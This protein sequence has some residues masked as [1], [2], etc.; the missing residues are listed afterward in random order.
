M[1]TD[2]KKVRYEVLATDGCARRGRLHTRCGTVETP[3]FMPVGTHATVKGMRPDELRELG[4]DILLSNAF[5]L[6]LRPGDE[7]IARH[8]GLHRFMGWDGC[9][10]TDSGGYQVFSLAKLRRISDDGVSFSSPIDGASVFLSPER[11]MDIQH[12]IGADIIMVLDQCPGYPAPRQE[13]EEAVLRS[14]SWA[15]RCRAH[16]GDRPSSLFAIIQGGMHKDLRDRCLTE[17]AAMD[18]DGYA[19]G[20]LAVGEEPANRITML[21][22]LA[23]R[24]PADKPR[25][26]MGVGTPLDLVESVRAGVDMFDCVLPTRNA[27]NGHLYVSQG[28]LR[29]RNAAHRNSMEPLD[30]E[31]DC[32]TCRRYSRAYLHHLYSRN[33]M[34]AAHL[35]TQHNLH[36]YRTLMEK[37]RQA[38]T[39]G[40]LDEYADAFRQRMA[41]NP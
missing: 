24:M 35:G 11:C 39:D 27:R 41:S 19:I 17:L 15:E 9:L 36:Y 18:F 33:E 31:C 8:G 29:I 28:V 5:H 6:S 1:S 20:G 40:K 4:F 32:L 2:K 14:L 13:V 25:Y 23:P 22:W 7:L 34:L 38:I 12:N 30:A 26:L 10:L 21:E 37:L 16:H 3:V